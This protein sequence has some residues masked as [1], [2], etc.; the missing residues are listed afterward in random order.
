MKSISQNKYNLNDYSYKYVLFDA[1]CGYRDLDL[2]L[3][4]DEEEF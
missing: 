4:G 2:K 3:Y 1:N